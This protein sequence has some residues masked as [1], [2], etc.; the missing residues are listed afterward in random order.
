[1]IDVDME[2]HRGGPDGVVRIDNAD[3]LARPLRLAAR[4]AS[5]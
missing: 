5:R 4:E 3:Y 2:A 1:M